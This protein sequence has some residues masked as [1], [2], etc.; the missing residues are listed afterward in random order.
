MVNL[1]NSKLSERQV[2]RI[3]VIEN[4]A[5]GKKCS[6][7]DKIAR[8]YIENAGYKG[9]FG[10]ALGQSVGLD[11]HEYPNFSPRC[12]EI[13]CENM[14]LTV[15]PGVYIENEFGVRIENMII[16]GKNGA[17]VITNSPTELIIL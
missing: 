15:E 1:D 17:R 7:I 12:D 10:H 13:L 8:D 3:G 2:F 9:L 16:V 11:I 14:V 5:V 4:I 6:Q